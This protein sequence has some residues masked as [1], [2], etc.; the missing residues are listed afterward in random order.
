MLIQKQDFQITIFPIEE[1]VSKG[2]PAEFLISIIPLNGY[3]SEVS[4]SVSGLPSGMNYQLSPTHGIPPFSSSLTIYTGSQSEA[5]E[6]YELTV[7]G[8]GPDL[9]HSVH[10]KLII[11]DQPRFELSVSPNSDTINIPGSAQFSIDVRSINQ[12]NGI[13]NL[14]LENIPDGVT[15][16]FS[17]SSERAPFRT[18]LS[19]YASETATPGNNEL[20]LIGTSGDLHDSLQIRLLLK[21]EA[22]LLCDFTLSISPTEYSISAGRTANFSI[23]VDTIHCFQSEVS[24]SI[25]GL[26]PGASYSFSRQFFVPP[27]SSTLSITTLPSTAS[28]MYLMTIIGRGPDKEHTCQATL[29]VQHPPEG[30]Y[31][32]PNPANPQ[33][34][35]VKIHFSVDEY[36][37]VTIRILDV[38]GNTVCT[39]IEELWFNPNQPHEVEWSGRNENSDMVANGVYFLVITLPNNKRKIA[40]FAILR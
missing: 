13:V 24:L 19:I 25:N 8:M 17:T 34:E 12:F 21:R 3:H 16:V 22:P 1:T 15:H 10:A 6:E 18:F 29:N 28:G 26:P 33:Q 39:L 40:P 4:L 30:I 14:S 7:I 32:Y 2:D 36:S 23:A 35:S 37:P 20:T 5:N 27:G 38:S 31:A 9:V 11:S